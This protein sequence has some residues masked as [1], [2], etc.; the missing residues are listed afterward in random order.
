MGHFVIARYK[1]FP[2]QEAALLSLVREH[3]PI[4]KK[5][6]LV[7]NRIPY[8]MRASDG[9]L[10]EVF[11]WKSEKAI[12]QAHSN[13]RVLKM[14]EDFGAVCE[15]KPFSTLPEAKEMFPGFE[16]VDL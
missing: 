15:F 13:P 8:V 1:P 3:I 12:E 4:L 2:G 9:S 7:T 5:E 16:P 6:A 11:E 10:I 14:W